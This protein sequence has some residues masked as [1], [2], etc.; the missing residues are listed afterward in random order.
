MLRVSRLPAISANDFHDPIAQ[1]RVELK[2]E[3]EL[4][5]ED[6]GG[7]MSPIPFS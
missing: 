4:L 2:G 5:A 3:N 7:E 6:D 1:L